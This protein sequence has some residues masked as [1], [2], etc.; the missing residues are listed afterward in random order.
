MAIDLTPKGSRGGQMPRLPGRLMSGMN[1]LIFRLF[2]GRPFFGMRLLQLTTVGAKSGQ[3]R[4]TTLGYL[5]DGENAWLITASAAGAARHPAWYFNL[6]KNPD[7][8]WIQIG[9]RKIKVR[10]ES[11][12]GTDR[13]N[14]YRRFETTTKSY[15]GYPQKTDREIPV[16]RLTAT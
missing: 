14:A 1:A 2:R 7:R 9:E 5:P 3:A 13:D 16:V 6:A 10:P 12:K 11:L 8:V 4:T 15:T